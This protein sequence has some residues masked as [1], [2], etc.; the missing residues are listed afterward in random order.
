MKELM[1]GGAGEY[2]ES[3]NELYGDVVTINKT[4]NLRDPSNHDT[5]LGRAKAGE[6][7]L[8][9]RDGGNHP[10]LGDKF[11][12]KIV[13][14]IGKNGKQEGKEYKLC[15]N[16]GNRVLTGVPEDVKRLFGLDGKIDL[17]DKETMRK[18]RRGSTQQFEE[19][20]SQSELNPAKKA[21]L[22]AAFK[23]LDVSYGRV[24][25]GSSL[26]RAYAL[27]RS[28]KRNGGKKVKELFAKKLDFGM[29]WKN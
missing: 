11:K 21:E 14:K 18:F 16:D 20:V 4:E 6:R 15:V 27:D 5:K 10:R 22:I 24:A 1:E 28:A 17:K 13:K 7:Y 23:V 25:H 3:L 12:Y 29:S 19:W 9:I 26:E 2:K 8:I